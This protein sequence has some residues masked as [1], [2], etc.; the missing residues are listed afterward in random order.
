LKNGKGA[1]LSERAPFFPRLVGGVLWSFVMSWNEYN[2]GNIF[3]S[4]NSPFSITK[5]AY[6][7]TY[8]ELLVDLFDLF[9]FNFTELSMA[10]AMAMITMKSEY[11]SFVDT[12][13]KSRVEK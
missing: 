9:Y 7:Y 1:D 11:R 3:T 4:L 8:K 5:H 12:I 13:L 6:M 2:I 10:M